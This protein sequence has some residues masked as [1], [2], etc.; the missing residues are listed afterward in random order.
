ML[1]RCS[2]CGETKPVSEFHRQARGRYGV[3]AE[4]KACRS[5]RARAAYAKN[6]ETVLA[7][8]AEYVRANKE[9]VRARQRRRYAEHI[10]EERQR[11]RDYYLRNRDAECERSRRKNAAGKD[12]DRA[13]R[14][15][16]RDRIRE[17]QQAYR[18]KN[19][20]RLKELMLRWQRANQDRC[21]MHKAN[22]KAAKLMAFPSWA[23]EA[24]IAKVYERAAEAERLTG[25]KHHVDHIVPL[26]SRLVCGMHVPWNLR[27]VPARENT[28]KGN[29]HWPDM[30]EGE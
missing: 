13:R 7:Q 2:S 9:L 16:D 28:A 11:S 15:R 1:K 20:E 5:E 6:R 14:M 3:T 22:Y 21:S 18:Q 27:V 12:K 17:V 4:C 10:Q 19:R 25:V 30:P 24:E 8:Q 26:Q 29:R 23:D